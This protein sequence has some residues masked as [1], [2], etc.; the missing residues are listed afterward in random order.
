MKAFARGKR[1]TPAVARS[2]KRAGTFR[3]TAG[4]GIRRQQAGFDRA[5][6]V[7]QRER[8]DDAMDLRTTR[9]AAAA[10]TC[11]SSGHVSDR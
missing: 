2:G 11:A 1:G 5:I 7:V 8:I 9:I 3:R 10:A 4:T 6:Q